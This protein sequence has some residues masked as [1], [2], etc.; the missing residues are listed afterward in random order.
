MRD[1]DIES[2]L[3]QEK[4]QNIKLVQGDKGNKIKINVFEDGQPVS[5]A[6]CSITAKY[7]RADNQVVDG[8]VENISGNSFDAVMDS[9]IT[10]VAGTLKMLFTIEKDDV[11]VSTFLLLADV[12]EG[13]GESTGSSGGSTGGGEV[14]VDLSDYYKKN[15][16]YSKAQIDSQ[17]KDIAYLSLTK[18]TDGKVYIKK[19][20]GTLLGTGIEIGGSDVDLS[21]ISMSM[22]G[23]TLK[24][25][26]NGTQIA[27]VEIPT[28]VVTDEQ[29][30]SIIQSKIDDGTLT[31]LTLG[32]NSVSTSNVQDKSITPNKTNFFKE[33]YTNLLYGKEWTNTGYSGDDQ[34]KFGSNFWVSDYV[35][36]IQNMLYTIS[37]KMNTVYGGAYI[38]KMGCYDVDKTYLGMATI[39]NGKDVNDSGHTWIEEFTLL[40]NTK[41]IRIAFSNGQGVGNKLTTTTLANTIISYTEVDENT[42]PNQ[43]I[44]TVSED[45]L[46]NLIDAILIDKSVTS[47]KLSDVAIKE[48]FEN[49]VNNNKIL[50]YTHMKMFD[51]VENTDNLFT[52]IIE[53]TVNANP[54]DSTVNT[55][56]YGFQTLLTDFIDINSNTALCVGLSTV[57]TTSNTNLFS[58]IK[59]VFCFDE[60]KKYLGKATIENVDSKN[61]TDES[62]NYV[63]MYLRWRTKNFIE[64]TKYVR[65]GFSRTYM[66]RVEIDDS[67]II[68]KTLPNFNEDAKLISLKMAEHYKLEGTSNSD[69]INTNLP[70]ANKKVVWIGDSLTNWGGGDGT[71]G[72]TGFLDIIKTN[73]GVDIYNQGTAGAS[74]EYGLGTWDD[75]HTTYTPAEGEDKYTAIGRVATLIGNKDTFT[76]DYVI[77]MMGSNRRADGETTD[78]YTNLYTMCGAIKHC[79][80][81]IYKNFPGCAIG[82]VLPPQ[83]LEGMEGQESANEKIKTIA[84]Y[85]SV[86]TFDIFHEGGLLNKTRNPLTDTANSGGFSD[87]L[88]L[89]ELGMKILGRKFSHWLKTL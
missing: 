66:T 51:M 80:L 40:E 33:E 55:D 72:G 37:P 52:G 15:E 44:F 59:G 68:R 1:Y 23:Q 2:D 32:D 21:K 58:T 81:Q 26:N 11:K 54:I 75:T 18:H 43:R 7:K 30:T 14:T 89:S 74:W 5:L 9:D 83:R 34:S 57:S 16:T 49:N 87:G 56:S 29:L 13:I 64:N 73:E 82:V 8:T 79:L 42:D 63:S 12:R 88:H 60:N 48:Q 4:F 41:Y 65:F 17:F 35:E 28:A 86:P 39:T 53:E 31:S 61:N 45:Y 25:L 70:L 36:T 24:L 20:D 47:D 3:K 6:G 77:F 67:C 62:G 50:D 19:Q 78:E 10:K 84:N 85:Y 71:I 46:Q 22:N 76:P 38:G 27:T 69:S